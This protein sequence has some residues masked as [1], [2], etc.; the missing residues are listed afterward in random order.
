MSL[1]S[2]PGTDRKSRPMSLARGAAGTVTFV[3][4]LAVLSGCG[5][6]LVNGYYLLP[7]A[8]E[9][10]I[11]EEFEWWDDWR[12]NFDAED[13]YPHALDVLGG[14]FVASDAR[15]FARTWET[16]PTTLEVRAEWEV[17]SPDATPIRDN[18][19]AFDFRIMLDTSDS[20]GYV[21]SGVRVELKL[22]D[23][24]V[25][26]RL[27]I[28]DDASGSSASVT[29]STFGPTHGTIE[30]T[31]RR[32][33]NASTVSAAVYDRAGVLLLETALA[34]DRRW[35]RDA[36]LMVEASAYNDGSLIEAR[37][38]DSVHALH[39]EGL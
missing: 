14:Y 35:Q 19:D 32:G 4:A 13:G 34:L 11:S 38:I 25:D 7:A 33:T 29:N 21:P 9:A 17:W 26:D 5:G 31:F 2:H 10:Y 24:G 15:Q 36:H 16:L 20:L 18:G 1:P 8:R 23:G 22:F 28:I 3:A 39:V 6:A 37:A 12:W 27:T 30:A